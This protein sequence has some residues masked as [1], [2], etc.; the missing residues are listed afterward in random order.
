MPQSS[1]ILKLASN[2]RSFIRNAATASAGA[3]ALGLAA[4]KK[5]FAGTTSS[6]PASP[7]T[8]AQIFTA[9]LVAEDLAI[10]FYY[11]ALIGGVI[12]DPNLAGPGGTATKVSASGNQS[13]VYYLRAAL[14]EENI[15]ADLFRS[16][17]GITGAPYN[18]PYLKFYFNPE[19]FAS[20][21]AFVGMLQALENAFIAAYM[22][23][24][25]EFSLLAAVGTAQT[26][27]GVTYQPTDFVY[28][29]G[30]AASILGV[31]SE[32]RAL[33]RSISPAL[34]PANNLNYESQDGIFTVYNGST[35]AVT[36]LTPFLSP[37]S[38]LQ[39]YGFPT[40]WANSGY[41][42]NTASGSIPT[43]YFK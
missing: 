18:D 30:I 13:N 7:D 1:D 28:Y 5:L 24:V 22:A 33:G 15:H 43:Q 19:V 32:H 17:L 39:E 11:N 8:P 21:N 9:A 36:A 41:V 6:T 38:G 34:F 26:I 20:L 31:E 29:A 25:Q 12:Q 27:G 14:H 37:G 42:S 23:A 16:L 3:A 10:T 4:P 35:S 40:C 2:R